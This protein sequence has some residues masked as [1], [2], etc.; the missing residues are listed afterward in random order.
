MIYVILC[1]EVRPKKP[2]TGATLM[3][4]LKLA[5]NEDKTRIM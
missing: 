1:V 4:S 2:Y 3:E 5:V